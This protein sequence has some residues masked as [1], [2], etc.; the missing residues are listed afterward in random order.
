MKKSVFLVML[1]ILIP[2]CFSQDAYNAK[3]LVI[4]LSISS[5][6]ELSPKS[7]DYKVDYVKANLFLFP[8]YG[9]NQE[10]LSLGTNP[11]AE[12]IGENVLF[13]W[14]DPEMGKLQYQV[15]SQVRTNDNR[16][17]VRNKIKFPIQELPQN[18]II[19]TQ[20]S[21]TIDSTDPNIIKLASELASGEDD[22]YVVVHNMGRWVKTNID[23][24]LSTLTAGVSQKA[25]WVL[26][27]KQ[28]VCDELT[29]LFI[30]LLRT[31][32][33]PA[34][35]ISGVSYTQATKDEWGAHGW[36][37]VYFPGY[38]W[39]PFDV[40]YGEFGYIDPTHITLNAAIDADEPS[41]KYQW[42][43][44]DAELITYDMDIDAEVKQI[45]GRSEPQI[46]LKGIAVKDEV[47]FGSY[48][49]IETLVENLGD[50]YYATELHI[51]KPNEVQLRCCETKSILLE[52][53][54]KRKVYWT[55]SID[56][57]LRQRSIYTFPIIVWSSR[58][59]T[60]QTDFKS[61]FL[62]KSYSQEEIEDLLAQK[63]IEES[64]TYSKNVELS[65]SITKNE[66]YYDETA[67]I[68]CSVKNI[69][70]V[71]LEGI[72][73]CGNDE[74]ESFDL[75]I[76][77]TGYKEFV[78]VP[79]QVGEYEFIVSAENHEVSK[80][81]YIR[82]T[83]LDKPIVSIENLES[84]Q[85]V[86][87]GDEFSIEFLLNKNSLSVPKDVV[88]ELNQGRIPKSWYMEELSS[89]NKFKV[90]MNS[91]DLGL[92]QNKF[93]IKVMY[94]DDLGNEYLTTKS[95]DVALTDVPASHLPLVAL[96]S[97]VIWLGY[98]NLRKLVYMLIIVAIVFI[99]S[100][101]FITKKKKA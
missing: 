29:N 8:R 41:T 83:V 67:K 23:Y 58:N 50:S 43:G 42:Y 35:F 24:D 89:E 90:N 28:G 85:S 32:G 63:E 57:D 40:T 11:D 10:V 80:A 75:G 48:N 47:G 74:C 76:T 2:I 99:V 31:L 27:T 79:S 72:K 71:L 98:D 62:K 17:K 21:D 16:V 26:D 18:I 39:I 77:Q 5:E 87:Y 65:C 38:G 55:I 61:S 9:L 4:D 88:I 86:S 33:I 56:D 78:I 46:T 14:D 44:R 94:K 69:G 53:N 6:I 68:D 30:A 20:P 54:E 64:K 60:S 70:N 49:L 34:R 13:R 66:F 97:V 59:V 73:L 3:N 45:S 7:D 95:F 52:P 84:P 100:L 81:S 82:Y 22:L 25:S 101:S 36:A 96:K 92:N 91:R 51:S 37:E 93:E 19:F 1:L 12:E 15:N